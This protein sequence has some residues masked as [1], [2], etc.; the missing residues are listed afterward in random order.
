MREDKPSF[1]RV[2][3]FVEDDL[4]AGTGLTLERDQSHYLANVM[5]KGAGDR[6]ALFN[7]RDGEFW[8]EIAEARRGAVTVDV[9]ERMREQAPEPDLW[10]AFAPI[11]R[12]A[13]D[14]VVAKATE[15]G[16]SRLIPV[17]TARTNTERVNTRRLRANAIEAAEQSERLTVPEIDEPV[18]FADLPR[19]A[20]VWR[21][22]RC[23][24]AGCRGCA[25][26][27]GGGIAAG[28]FDR[29]GRGFCPG[30]T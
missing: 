1:T 8:A 9:G 27:R 4:A 16:V 21:R 28:G 7:G 26:P 29:T 13:V 15:I 18:K 20:A 3:L 17:V 2:R 22:D 23:R 24:T 14:F 30:G 11:K 25:R 5:R 19:D 10:L 6:V 12:A